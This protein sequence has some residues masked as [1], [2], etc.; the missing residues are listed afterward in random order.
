M[1][2]GHERL[3]GPVVVGAEALIEHSID[4]SVRE[5]AKVEVPLAVKERIDILNFAE[6]PSVDR[7]IEAFPRE[8]RLPVIGAV[9]ILTLDLDPDLTKLGLN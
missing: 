8:H 3:V 6:G 9:N 1:Q 5:A 7:H 2:L 4:L